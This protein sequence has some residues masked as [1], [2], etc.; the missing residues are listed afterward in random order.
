M[1]IHE[2]ASAKE[3]AIVKYRI[4]VW[5]KGHSFQEL[6]YSLDSIDP[7]KLADEIIAVAKR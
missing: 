5:K 3:S 1:E 7:D 2:V 4:S 6:W